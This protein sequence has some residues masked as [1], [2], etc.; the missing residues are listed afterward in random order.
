VSANK[1]VKVNRVWVAGD[2]GSQIV[3]PSGAEQQVQGSVLDGLGGAM[4]QEITIDKGRVVQSNFHDYSLLRINQAAPVEVYFRRTENPPTGM[5]EPSFPPVVPALCNAI[6][7]ATGDRV[8]TL[9]LAKSGY[10]WA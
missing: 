3:N 1:T 7:A 4:G 8:R 6:F 2:V 10:R 9:P 5:G